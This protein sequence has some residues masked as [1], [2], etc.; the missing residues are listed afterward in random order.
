MLLNLF[1]AYSVSSSS[2]STIF[3]YPQI[4]SIYS[5]AFSKLIAPLKFGVPGSNLSGKL[6]RVNACSSTLEIAP[7]PEK[8]GWSSLSILS[9]HQSTPIPL[10]AISLCPVKNIKSQ[11]I[12]S[13]STLKCGT[14]CEASTIKR[15]L[16][17]PL[18]LGEGLG[19]RAFP[20]SS[21][22]NMLPVTF[23]T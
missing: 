19:V 18:P 21:K 14:L 17:P 2:T 4:F 22:S 6:E 3:S 5:K 7:P 10:S 20:T 23:E 15:G 8:A 12:F 1:K 11:P 13:T 9:F 16:C